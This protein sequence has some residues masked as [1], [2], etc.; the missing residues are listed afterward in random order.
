MYIYIFYNRHKDLLDIVVAPNSDAAVETFKS[1]FKDI[2][3]FGFDRI[4]VYKK[5]EI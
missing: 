4:G 2:V 3:I 1:H 5:N